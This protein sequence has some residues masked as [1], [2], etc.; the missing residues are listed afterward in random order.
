MILVR[1]FR[2]DVTSLILAA[3][4]PAVVM[5]GYDRHGFIFVTVRWRL[6][7]HLK[8]DLSHMLDVTR[9]C[10]YPYPRYL[11][12]YLLV[13]RLRLLKEVPWTKSFS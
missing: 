9:N 10:A 6:E 4:T 11:R 3:T 1:D 7:S 5:N 13:I 12:F 2:T 8:L